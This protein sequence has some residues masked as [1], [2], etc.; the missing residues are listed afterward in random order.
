MQLVP[1]PQPQ[2]SMKLGN[3]DQKRLLIALDHFLELENTLQDS[4]KVG[5][6]FMQRENRSQSQSNPYS[7]LVEISYMI[8]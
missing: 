3:V 1:I 2:V 8:R 5:N 4:L 6:K 7:N